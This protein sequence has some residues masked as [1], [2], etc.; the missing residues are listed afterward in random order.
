MIKKIIQV[1]EATILRAICKLII[2][3]TRSQLINIFYDPDF[4][5][6]YVMKFHVL[7][8]DNCSVKGLWVLRKI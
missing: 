7:A 1:I 3:A 4:V 2:K 5:Q 6:F 8:K